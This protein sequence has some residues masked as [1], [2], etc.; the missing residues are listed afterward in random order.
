[1]TG[2]QTCA[3]PISL[4]A[5]SALTSPILVAPVVKRV[6]A[7]LPATITT[8]DPQEVWGLTPGLL[9]ALNWLRDSTPTGTVLAVSNHWINPAETDGRN[10]YYS[11]F[12]EREIFVE[13]Y[14]PVRFGVLPGVDT[15]TERDF[16]YRQQLN[17]DVFN[18][19]DTQ[20]LAL[21]TQR[22]LVRTGSG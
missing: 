15:Q 16:V 19:A 20:A 22:Y 7:G 21:M 17:N 12:S 13:A 5:A 3:L 8:P 14:D 2:V 1:V 11:A 6:L 18:H 4:L 9:T 10:Y